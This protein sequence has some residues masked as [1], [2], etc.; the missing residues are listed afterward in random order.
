[1]T[2][3]NLGSVNIDH[4]YRL[5][6]L[7]A[8]GETIASQDYV[9]GLG[10]KG[11]NQSIAA[12]RAGAR[13]IHIGGIGSQGDDWVL[14]RLER[15]GVDTSRIMRIPDTVTGHAVILVDAGAENVIVL[16]PGANCQ[17]DPMQLK[18]ILSEIGPDDTLLLQNETNLQPEA[19]R[20]ARLAGARVI[21]SCAPF[22]I[23]AAR[24]VMADV[25]ILA[26]NEVEA[27]QLA[28]AMP[29][30]IAVPMMLVT[31]GAAGAE[32]RDMTTGNMITQ[33]AFPVVPVDTTGA[34]DCFAG[35]FAAGLDVGRNPADALR[36]AA[37]ASAIKVTRHG[38][39]DAIPTASEVAVFLKE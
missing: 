5:S 8:K 3:Y 23:D 28:D 17:L 36:H 18:Q 27:G 31:R 12:A 34:G 30:G 22:D 2:I 13:V 35:Y 1:M 26:L 9:Q 11:A 15:A 37:A 29:D 4:V 7:P 21:Y 38:A 25:S 20:M 6:Y 10:G 19:A 24:A 16:Y 33:T 39:G 32:Y 14:E